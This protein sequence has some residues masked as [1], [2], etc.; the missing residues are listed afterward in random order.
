MGGPGLLVE[1][2]GGV[3]DVLHHDVDALDEG[4]DVL[5]DGADLVFPLDLDAAGQI[6]M[7]AGEIRD[8]LA[9]GLQRGQGAVDGH[10]GEARDYEDG[11]QT[12]QQG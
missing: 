8:R 6:A 11:Q 4:V 5:G 9:E 2:P 12:L 10:V 1:L 7:A 3:G